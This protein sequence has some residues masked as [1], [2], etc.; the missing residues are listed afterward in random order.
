MIGAA[1]L[2]RRARE[3]WNSVSPISSSGSPTETMTAG[4]NHGCETM[5]A[6]RIA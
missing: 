4:Q 2:P 1:R 5:S 6:M 3:L